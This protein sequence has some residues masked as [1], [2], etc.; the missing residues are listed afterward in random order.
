VEA[1]GEGETALAL[2]QINTFGLHCGVWVV[3]CRLRQ[4]YK[5]S[6][7][8]APCERW[9][10]A[11]ACAIIGTA[12]SYPM[13]KTLS[14]AT[15]CVL[16]TCVLALQAS[17]RVAGTDQKGKNPQTDTCTGNFEATVRLGPSV[18]TSLTGVLT[19]EIDAH[20]ELSG[21]LTT[22]DDQTIPVVG[23]V[24][25]RAINLAFEL[26]KPEGETPG[27]YL[28][29]MGTAWTTISSETQCGGVMGGTFAGPEGGDIGDWISALS[30][31]PDENKSPRR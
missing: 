2:S 8:M 6:V 17:P 31:N 26:Q 20:G 16:V 19:V 1:K 15:L 21:T 30:P 4:G 5:V 14:I 10:G 29:G 23:R 18:G 22:N 13:P 11:R 25:G 27:L 7:V 24:T 28:F 12:R 3:D 9:Q